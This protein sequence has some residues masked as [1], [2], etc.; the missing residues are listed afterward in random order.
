MLQALLPLTATGA[1]V[2][3]ADQAEGV[4]FDI[5]WDYARHALVPPA[6][7]LLPGTPVAQGW[8][9]GRVA[10]GARRLGPRRGTRLWLAL[11]LQ[12]WREGLA[13]DLDQVNAV[14]LAQIQVDRCPVR[15]TRL[16]GTGEDA[17][18][19]V[20]V[21]LNEQAG[22]AAGNLAMVSQAAAQAL[23]GQSWRTLSERSAR[24]EASDP[25]SAACAWR[26]AALRSLVTPMPLAEAAAVPLAV[27]PPNRV[28]L[29]NPAQGLQALITCQFLRPGW[30]TRSRR[31]AA[32]LPTPQ[33]RLGLNRLMGLLAPRVLEAGGE[34]RRVRD[35]LEDTWLHGAVQRHWQ[36]WATALGD[37]AIQ[38][39]VDRACA[40]G[41]SGRPTIQHDADQAVAG[42]ALL[43]GGQAGWTR[44]SGDIVLPATARA[45]AAAAQPGR[46]RPAALPPETAHW[47]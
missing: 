45:P 41:L 27:L 39:L 4:G 30:A 8:R 43:D 37:E 13:F 46:M 5:G 16:D 12:A 6:Q 44:P 29:L 7:W 40:A 25:A 31:L 38:T 14:H 19:P 42:W 24:A 33:A 32:L 11:R 26:L 20:V 17:D 47:C 3:P 35:A 9:A 10:F 28:R 2:R 22:Y 36:P 1:W 15:R 21:R 18:A 23:R 34:P